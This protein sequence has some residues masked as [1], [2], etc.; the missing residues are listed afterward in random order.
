MTPNQT[1]KTHA[2]LLIEHIDKLL[3]EAEKPNYWDKINP[4]KLFFSMKVHE[5]GRNGLIKIMEATGNKLMYRSGWE[6]RFQGTKES[7]TKFKEYIKNN[8][9]D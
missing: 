8:I 1:D 4:D 6:L 7:L 3:T 2:E 5:P 9:H